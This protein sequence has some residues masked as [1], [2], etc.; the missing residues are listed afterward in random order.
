MIH[1]D[2][3]YQTQPSLLLRMDLAFLYNKQK[4]ALEYGAGWTGCTVHLVT[5]DP[6]PALIE[7]DMV[8]IRNIMWHYVGLVRTKERMARADR[9]LQ[10]LFHEIERFYRTS[11][12]NDSLIGLR[13][14]IQAARTVLFAAQRNPTSRGTH[15]RADLT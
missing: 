11:A 4:Q 2:R 6:D 5:E 9:E 13:N 1:G 12:L 7:G 15:F 8:T 14:A 10:H 3:M